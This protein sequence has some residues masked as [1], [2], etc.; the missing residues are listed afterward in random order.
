[1]RKENNG[2]SKKSRLKTESHS[3]NDSRRSASLVEFLRDSP[4]A[5]AIADGELTP[6]AFEPKPDLPRGID[7]F[8]AEPPRSASGTAHS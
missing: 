4:L 5:K 1:M 8:D 6:D 2:V 7:P 3:V